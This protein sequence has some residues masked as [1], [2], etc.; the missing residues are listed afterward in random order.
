MSAAT[1]HVRDALI[2]AA[3]TMLQDVADS[4]RG[5]SMQAEEARE[6]LG[7]GELFG[8]LGTLT[9]FEA[10]ARPLLEAVDV[11]RTLMLR[12]RDEGGR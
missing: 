4:A 9:D 2:E 12:A 10:R 1:N 7:D 6:A 5:I 8:A 3:R 11:A